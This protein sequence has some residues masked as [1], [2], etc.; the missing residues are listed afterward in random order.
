MLFFPERVA[1]AGLVAYIGLWLVAPL[2]RV[3]PMVWVPLGYIAVCYSAFF[4]GC[5]LV[6]GGRR[7]IARPQKVSSFSSRAFWAIACIGA[8]GMAMRLYDKLFIRGVSLADSALESREM[9][10]DAEAGPVAAVGG[11]LYPFCYVPLILWWAREPGNR[12]GPVA[13]GAA[14]LLFLLPAVDALLLL[15]RSQMLVAFSMMFFSAACV[16]F[17]GN[18]LHPRL[19]LPVVLGVA[20]LVT[21]SVLAF[22]S[23]LSQMDRDLVSSILTSAYGF[24][25]TP[26]DRALTAMQ[27]E[28]IAGGALGAVVPVLQYYLHGVFEFGLLWSRPDAQEFTL[29]TQ[30]FAPY[31]KALSMFKLVGYPEFIS[32]DIYY[33]SGVFTTFFGPLWIDFGWGGPLFMLGFGMLAKVCANGARG[34]AVAAMPLHAYFCVVLFFMPVV[35]FMISAQGMYIINAFLLTWIFLPPRNSSE[36]FYSKGMTV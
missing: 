35:N 14:V 32:S 3:F 15:S 34:G 19:I 26:N 33:R 30:T 28:G 2:E 12:L 31:F 18:A 17:R 4:L 20:V 10:A 22:T 9:L 7:G 13:L 27:G 16:L 36:G 23:R 6:A 11:L 1:L 8:A 5:L 25:L 24:V 29:G 21:V